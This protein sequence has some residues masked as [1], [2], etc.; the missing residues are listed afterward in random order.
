MIEKVKV[1]RM[2]E[3]VNTVLSEADG[4]SRENFNK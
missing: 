2:I 4:S 1:I 3:Y